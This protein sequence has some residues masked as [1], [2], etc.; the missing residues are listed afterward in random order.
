MPGPAA[1]VSPACRSSG[2]HAVAHPPVAAALRA[3][4]VPFGINNVA[5]TAAVASLRAQAELDVRVEALVA[6]RTRV[7]AALRAHGVAT[8][9]SEANFFWL[10]LG[11]RSGKFAEAC[12]AAGV[13]VRPFG[14]EGV[15]V[16]IGEPEANDTVV[17]I[18]AQFA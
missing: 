8:P 1:T 10:R 2:G 15:R 12:E 7:F 4:A 11:E 18:A 6:E 5:Q 13:T 17:E 16:T 14:D 9:D 3:C